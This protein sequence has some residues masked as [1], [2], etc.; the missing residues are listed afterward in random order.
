MSKRTSI[1]QYF[2]NF[3]HLL[4]ELIAQKVKLTTNEVR[5][6]VIIRHKMGDLCPETNGLLIR[7]RLKY[8]P[9]GRTKEEQTDDFLGW[10]YDYVLPNR[11]S[12]TLFH[13]RI[14]SLITS[15]KGFTQKEIYDILHKESRKS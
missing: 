7:N 6:L 11:E 12:I 15:V 1:K 13:A 14:I 10:I 5:V 8:T 3:N 4:D 9:K 2:E